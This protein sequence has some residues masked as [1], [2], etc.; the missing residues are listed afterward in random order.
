[1]EH[2]MQAAF[3]S[4]IFLPALL[5]VVL[6]APGSAK[7]QVVTDGSVGPRVS[8][9]GGQIE[10]GA[11]LGSR[12]GN[13]LFHSFE[14]FGVATGQTATFTG[15]D[16]IRNVISRVT[17]GET[18]LIDGTLSSKVGQADLYFLNPAGVVLGPDAHLDV[19]G[20]MHVS[21]AHELR[22][23]DGSR[24]SAVDQA[25]SGLTVAAPEAFGFLDRTPG[26]IAVDQSQLQLQTGKTLSLVGSDIDVTGGPSG[27]ISVQNGTVHLASLDSA[28][29]IK[30]SDATVQANQGTIHL[31]NQARIDTSG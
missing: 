20:S 6:A 19:P 25:G 2:P 8:L 31:T 4:Q 18:S 30:I 9:R 16:T 13:N 23:A 10:I 14:K 11:A 29:Q 1:M 15:P 28:G 21:T 22:F 5:L 17:G 26:R 3:R 24:F 7:S 12:H 27:R